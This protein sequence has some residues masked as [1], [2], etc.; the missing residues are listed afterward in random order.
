MTDRKTGIDQV[1]IRRATLED[2]DHLCSLV[3]AFQDHLQSQSLSG[4]DVSIALQILLP[5]PWWSLRSH[6]LGPRL[7]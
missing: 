2:L 6:S 3:V 4:A 7:L 1:E 5:D